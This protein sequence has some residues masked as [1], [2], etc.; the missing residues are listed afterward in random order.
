MIE[1]TNDRNA[2]CARVVPFSEDGRAWALAVSWGDAAEG[3]PIETAWAEAID[4]G[5]AA[6][7]GD[8]ATSIGSRVVTSAS[9]APEDLVAARAA[10]HRD[11][12]TTR[13]FRIRGE[14]IEWR[15]SIDDALAALPEYHDEATLSWRPV[16]VDDEADM[17]RAADLLIAAREGDPDSDPEDDARGFI[18]AL[19]KDEDAA[20]APERVQ[21]GSCEGIPVVVLLLT[22]YPA[23]GWATMSYLAVRP[24]FRGRGIGREA[25][26]H[27]LRCMKAMGGKVYH[28]G[29]GATNAAARALLTSLGGPPYR[30]MEEWRLVRH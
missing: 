3:L 28:D 29:T 10:M 8:G 14:R 24:A 26:A 21:I 19:L 15:Q 20:Q 12:L 17:A 5:I 25:M 23:D 27:G 7:E 4:A 11:A 6:C 18:E 1:V 16:D 2:V 22:V 9:G 13:G 30:V